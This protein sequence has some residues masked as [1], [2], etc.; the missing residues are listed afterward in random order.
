MELPPLASLLE[1]LNH[2]PADCWPVG[3]LRDLGNAGGFSGTKLVRFEALRGPLLV[4]VWPTGTTAN[5]L[6]AIHAW[7]LPLG[8]TLPYVAEPLETATGAT[9]VAWGE[10]LAQVEPWKPGSA[11]ATDPALG[12]VRTAAEALARVHQFWRPLGRRGASPGLTR[13]LGALRELQNGGL[14]RLEAAISA[15]PALSFT[16]TA[17]IWLTQARSVLEGI[18]RAHRPWEERALLLQP[19]LRDCRAAHWLF[20]G[21]ALTGLIDFGAVDADAPAFDL[22]RLG[23]D[24]WPDTPADE[25]TLLDAYARHAPFGETDRE[26]IR[27]LEQ[28]TALLAGANWIRWGVLEHRRFERTG[29]V[30]EGI[31]RS[32]HWLDSRLTRAR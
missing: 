30:D 19:C 17:R 5:H 12:Q 15:E 1:W 6:S 3:P 10:R 2:Y 32:L 18:T 28:S 26:L 11:V 29:A 31:D 22:A 9:F 4:R 24:W 8:R 13:R 7:V 21:D 16:N 25:A 20:T 23:L 27:V 14:D